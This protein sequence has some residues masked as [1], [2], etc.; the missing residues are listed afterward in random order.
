MD[1]RLDQATK[2]RVDIANIKSRYIVGEINRDEAKALAKP[3][4]ERINEQTVRKTDE[5]NKKYH[6]KRSPALL[7]FV[8]AMRGI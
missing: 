1:N 4:I 5:L 2:N 6:M 8:N 7:D 3:I